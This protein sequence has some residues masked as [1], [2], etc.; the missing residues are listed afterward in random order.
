MNQEFEGKSEKE[1]IDNAIQALGA[2]RVCFGTDAP[3]KRQHVALAMYNAPLDGEVSE[4]Q[5]ALVM[6]GNIAR[7]FDL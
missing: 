2:A 6:G 7:L 4:E 5:K 1:A 3:F